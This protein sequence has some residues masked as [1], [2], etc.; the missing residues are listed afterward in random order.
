MNMKRTV[1]GQD[2]YYRINLSQNLLGEWIVIRTFGS[3]KRSSPKGEIVNVYLQQI[4]AKQA[5]EKLFGQKLK[6]GY[7]L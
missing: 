6:K 2:R 3:E 4:D 7:R 5:Y 1:N